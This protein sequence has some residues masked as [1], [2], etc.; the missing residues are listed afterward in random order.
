M[1]RHLGD[2]PVSLILLFASFFPAALAS[3]CFFHALLLARLQV[4]GMT[5]Y[6][7]DN[8]FL[9]YLPLETA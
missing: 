6:F 4:K 5:F 8:V 9:L 7:L 3:Q 2:D 1:G